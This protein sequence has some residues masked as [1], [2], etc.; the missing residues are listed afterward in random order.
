MKMR[1]LMNG[2]TLSLK[3]ASCTGCGECVEVCPHGVFALEKGKALI[4]DQESCMEC[5]ACMKNCA[6]GAITVKADVGCA[7]AVIQGILRG[8]EPSCGCDGGKPGAKAGCC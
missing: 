2:D 8:T 6:V 1:Y 7:A 4:V 3:S 5:G